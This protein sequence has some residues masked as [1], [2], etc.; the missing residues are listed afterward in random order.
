MSRHDGEVTANEATADPSPGGARRELA[1][2]AGGASF[3]FATRIGGAAAGYTTQL[4]LVRWIGAAELGHYVLSFTWCVILS[5]LA[6]VGFPSASLRFVG[7]ALADDR[8]GRIA[9]YVRKTRRIVLVTSSG[10]AVSG[11]IVAWLVLRHTAPGLVAPLVIALAAIPL[12][13]QI[14]LQNGYAHAFSWL[15]LMSLPNNVLRPG[16]LLAAICVAAVAGAE[17][18]AARVMAFHL[19]IIA[20]LVMTQAHRL[21]RRLD[22]ELAGI[23]PEYE[24]RRWI[25][26]AAPILLVSL[27]GGYFP[28]IQVL[29]A[30]FALSS[31]DI[32][33]YAVSLR[34]AFFIGLGLIAI[35]YV[36]TPKCSQLYA[37][38]RQAELQ[39]SI[40]VATALAALGA[41]LGVA[42]LAGFGTTI[43]GWF[44]P[45][46][47]AGHTAMILAAVA[48]LL[49]ALIGPAA[50]V[51]AVTGHQN[52]CLGVFAWSLG[53]SVVLNLVVVPIWGIDGAAATIVAV[54]AFSSFWLNRLAYRLVGVRCSV[55]A[56]AAGTR[57]GMPT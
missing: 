3:L 1:R 43:L 8:R 41:A 33:V 25:H 21:H 53:A 26:T 49:R 20:L 39:H 51:L 52:A 14:L 11:A 15:A 22:A 47:A 16:L 2:V 34:T 57:R 6:S 31:A 50:E 5:S 37:S 46:F 12:F 18:S 36:L 19:G 56:L 24:T 23:E 42:V 29:L 38:G 30:G 17:L 35:H 28:D 44:G 48:L 10:V 40:S 27:F 7:E 45:E 55:L 9:G 54:V 13:A 32:A 4:L